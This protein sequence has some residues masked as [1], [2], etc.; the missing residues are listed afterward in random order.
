MKEIYQHTI[1]NSV[2]CAGI[3]LHTGENVN[4]TINPAEAGTGIIFKRVDVEDKNNLVKA[5]YSN[6]VETTLGTT[7]ANSDGVKV[8]TIEHLMAALW[9][10]GIDNALIEIDQAEVPIMDGSSEPFTFLIECAGVVVQEKPRKYIKIINQ[11]NYQDGDAQC[12]LSPD[13]GF[14]VDLEI[15]FDSKVIARQKASYDFTESAFKNVVSRARTFGFKKEVDYLR[16]LGLARGGSLDNAIVVSDEGVLNPEGLRYE[17]E[18]V[19]HKVLDCVG[20]L[21][22]SGHRFIGR[23]SGYKSGHGLNNKILRELFSNQK[24]WKFVS[25]TEDK[26]AI[27]RASTPQSRKSQKTA[28]VTELTIAV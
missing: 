11:V 5:L 12:S 25:F 15:N 26:N 3:G 13:A 9:G 2:S 6:V 8:A 24:N 17:D 23:F 27:E 20:D 10:A 19:R 4:L 28:V 21:F 16:S 22:L 14:I 18:F 7:I 1:A